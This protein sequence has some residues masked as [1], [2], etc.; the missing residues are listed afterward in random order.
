M[1]TDK[2]ARTT[3]VLLR[4]TSEELD[5]VSRRMGV[6]RSVLVRDVLREPV[7]L[8]AG[9]LRRVPED[10]PVTAEQAAQLGDEIQ[11]DL[12]DFIERHGH[13]AGERGDRS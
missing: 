6:S 12:V 8:M 5:Y 3:F 11:L 1:N 4:E 9:W 13:L 10:Q 2:L 7:S